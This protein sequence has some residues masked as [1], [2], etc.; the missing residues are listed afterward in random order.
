MGDAMGR[1]SHYTSQVDGKSEVAPGLTG[2]RSC[3]L[4]SLQLTARSLSRFS[5]FRYQRPN[6]SLLVA[7]A[8]RSKRRQKPENARL[9]P[10]R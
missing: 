8:L 2:K 10:Y 5:A 3:P 4:S 7:A 1:F 6:C 9:Q